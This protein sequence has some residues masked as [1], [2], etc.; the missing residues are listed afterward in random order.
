MLQA[1]LLPLLLLCGLPW[2]ACQLTRLLALK[3][4][5]GLSARLP[6]APRAQVPLPVRN[7]GGLRSQ[8]QRQ[9]HHH[10]HPGVRQPAGVQ[11]GWAG[12]LRQAARRHR[13]HRQP[14]PA[15]KACALARPP[16][17][18]GVQ[19]RKAPHPRQHGAQGEELSPAAVLQRQR[20]Q[21][22]QR[23]KKEGLQQDLL[24]YQHLGRLL[25]AEI[26]Q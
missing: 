15:H 8:R 2:L 4:A 24:K 26:N 10:R 25:E 20:E 16:R 6:P 3:G 14:C 23:R 7:K 21:Q 19:G 18:G 13:L 22:W 1:L 12:Q 17:H 11:G 9:P 5:D